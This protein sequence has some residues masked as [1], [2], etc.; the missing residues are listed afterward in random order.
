MKISYRECV[1]SGF[2]LDKNT[3]IKADK[4]KIEMVGRKTCEGPY[5]KTENARML[6]LTNAVEMIVDNNGKILGL[7]SHPKFG[8]WLDVVENAMRNL[9]SSEK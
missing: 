6:V 5:G 3:F 9:K 2:W 4:G 8:L 1:Q 7:N